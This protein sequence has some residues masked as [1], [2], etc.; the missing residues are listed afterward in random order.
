MSFSDDL[1]ASANQLVFPPRSQPTA[2]WGQ[3]LREHPELRQFMLEGYE[4]GLLVPLRR[5]AKVHSGVVP[6]AN[7]FF[8]VRE[9]SFD[10]VPA[11]FQVTE[12]DYERVAVVQDGLKTPHKIER[13]C[14]RPVLKGPEALIGPSTIAETDERLFDCQDRSKDELRDLRANGALTYLRRGETVDYRVVSD[15]LKGGVPAQRAQIRNRRPYWY[16]LHS[17]VEHTTRLAVP[18]HFDYRFVASLIPAEQDA[19]V[20]DTLYSIE[21][22]S[23]TD[24]GFLSACL[25][26]LL[27]WYQLEMRGRTQHGQGVLKVKVADWKGVL[28][29]DPEA[30]SD[31]EQTALLEFFEPLRTRPT[32]S[33]DEEMTD[34]ERVRFDE[35]YISLCGAEDSTSLRQEVERHFRA[36]ISER[37]ERAKSVDSAKAAKTASQ[38][39]TASVDAFA[40]RIAASMEP[41]PNPSQFV[42]TDL[43]AR[44]INEILI[45]T[46]WEGRL[47]VGEDLLS[48]GEVFAGDQHIAS[49][50]DLLAAQ[51]VRAVLLHDPEATTVAVP[52]DELLTEIMHSGRQ[53][54]DVGK[55]SLRRGSPRSQAP[56]GMNGRS[57]RSAIAR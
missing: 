19:V 17:P 15:K 30:M 20:I 8:L 55:R 45:S 31:M 7:A 18:E 56:L 40:S 23:E 52:R 38:K 14:L 11:R 35:Q 26:S 25:N 3:I 48:Q 29:P 1:K 9:L 27:T 2:R 6:R 5:V 22:Y 49:A 54:A 46:P 41:Y 36:A 13:L 44:Y 53:N 33:V 4:K 12:Q 34:L 50:G 21:P 32:V 16:S 28:V 57:D 47:T 39:V 37:H 42:D 43:E 24:A 10:E 51:Y